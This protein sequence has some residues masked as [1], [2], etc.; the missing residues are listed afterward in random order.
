[1]KEGIDKIEKCQKI[2]IVMAIEKYL[3]EKKYEMGID[4]SRLTRQSEIRQKLK[5]INTMY[6][7]GGGH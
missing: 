7:E 6:S 5:K 1:M 3:K 4:E 2:K